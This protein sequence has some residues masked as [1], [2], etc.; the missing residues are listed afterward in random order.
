MKNKI[1]IIGMLALMVASV[2]LFGCAPPPVE[3]PPVVVPPEATIKPCEVSVPVIETGVAGA[4]SIV[5]SPEF[6][7]YNPNDY[8][9]TVRVL[10]YDMTI[11]GYLLGTRDVI[12][13]I[14]VPAK[15][16]ST[17]IGGM[18]TLLPANWAGII[19]T[20]DGLTFGEGFVKVV[21]LWKNL[22]GLLFSAGLKDAWDAAPEKLP[23]FALDGRI[24]T[25]SPEGQELITDY[26]ATY[27]RPAV[28]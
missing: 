20:K 21:P 6:D 28:L 7:I 16:T 18:I 24:E 23:V 3:V 2:G 19:A 9:V 15:G 10:R 8:A 14:C 26:S 11:E 12:V 13:N 27:Q 4:E 17:I 5:L 25:R 22:D 1:L